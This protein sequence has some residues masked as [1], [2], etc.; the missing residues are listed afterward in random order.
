M[1]RIEK[2]F[3]SFANTYKGQQHIPDYKPLEAKNTT[4]WAM[5]YISFADYDIE[6]FG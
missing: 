1:K 6:R 4:F 2:E 3:K 5:P